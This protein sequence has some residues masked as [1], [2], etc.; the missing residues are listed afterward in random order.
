MNRALYPSAK[1]DTYPTRDVN[2]KRYICIYTHM[3]IYTH[4]CG[5]YTNEIYR[6]LPARSSWALHY[7]SVGDC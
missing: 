1:V 6:G 7:L 4:A 2:D 5:H 3:H